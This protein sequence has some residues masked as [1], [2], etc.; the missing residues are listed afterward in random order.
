MPKTR[1]RTI[2]HYPKDT[3][4]V[5]KTV[6][7]AEANDWVER[8]PYE[9]SDEELDAELEDQAREEVMAELIRK[10]KKEIKARR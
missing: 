10:K 3:P 6:A 1:N 8:I 9:V 7:N 5:E 4:A 2:Y